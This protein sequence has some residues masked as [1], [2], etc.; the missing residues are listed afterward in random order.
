M[1]ILFYRLQISHIYTRYANFHRAIFIY[2]KRFQHNCINSVFLFKIKE[3]FLFLCTN[4][5]QPTTIQEWE[6][7]QIILLRKK[8]FYHRNKCSLLDKLFSI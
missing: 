2:N 8:R 1:L 3:Y 5:Q 7:R 6:L 4:P